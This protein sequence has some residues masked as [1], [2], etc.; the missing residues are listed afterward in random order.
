MTVCALPGCPEVVSQP[1]FTRGY[2][3]AH[4]QVAVLDALENMTG[5]LERISRDV[6][7]HLQAIDERLAAM[8]DGD[9]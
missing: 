5:Y 4:L 2:C 6:E 7:D 1:T 8:T 9:S 3:D